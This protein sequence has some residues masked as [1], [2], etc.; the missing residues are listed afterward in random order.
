MDIADRAEIAQ[1]LKFKMFEPR[2]R[3]SYKGQKLNVV[4]CIWS[5]AWDK[6]GE[7]IKSRLCVRG[8]SD[9]QKHLIDKHSS[10]ASRLSQRLICSVALISGHV[11]SPPSN[12]CD[13]THVSVDIKGAFLQGLRFEEPSKLA[14]KLGYEQ[15]HKRDV[16]IQPPADV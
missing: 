15:R 10:T 8:C 14:R 7:S 11:F 12:P 2:R 3:D 4:E 1:L 9:V 5:R 13:F 6:D 16:F